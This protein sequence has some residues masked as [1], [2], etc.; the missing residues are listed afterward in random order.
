MHV[1]NMSDAPRPASPAP[2]DDDDRELAARMLAVLRAGRDVRARKVRRL[3]AAVR[4]RAY[5]N[6]LKL[7]VALERMAEDAG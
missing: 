7:H 5:E 6:P 2:R 3:R 1:L 4:A